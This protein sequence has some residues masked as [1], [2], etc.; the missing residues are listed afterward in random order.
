MSITATTLTSLLPLAI[1]GVV[2]YFKPFLED[3]KEF[4]NRGR[5]MITQSTEAVAEALC[6]VV[7]ERVRVRVEGHQ[8]LARGDGRSEPD[9][10]GRVAE[11]ISRHGKLSFRVNLRNLIFRACYG[12]L[13]V[14][15]LV[16]FVCL[17]L[18]LV[19]KNYEVAILSVSLST[20]GAEIVCVLVLYSLTR[21]SEDDEEIL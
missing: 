13:L 7:E 18:S 5:R 4:K 15:V 21:R 12:A 17:V 19:T 16:G 11:L 14:G 20:A 2:S 6:A 9:L 8:N 3:Q 10:Y 1:G